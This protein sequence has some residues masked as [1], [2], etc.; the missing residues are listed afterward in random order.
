[1]P[2]TMLLTDDVGATVLDLSNLAQ[3]K[4]V[5]PRLGLPSTSQAKVA[6]RHLPSDLEDGGYR[7]KVKLDGTTLHN[8]FVWNVED[9]GDET[10]CYTTLQSVSPTVLFGKR[11]ARDADGDF[12]KPSVIATYQTG[13]QIMQQLIANSISYEGLLPIT[14]GTV[15]TG[16]VDLSGAPV[17]WPMTIREVQ[18]LLAGTG[19]LDVV[20]VPLDAAAVMVELDLYNGDFGVDRTGSVAFDYATG[21]RNVRAI[22]RTASMEDVCNKLWYYLGPRVLTSSD[23]AGDQHWRANIT[24]DDPGLPNPPGGDVDYPNPLGDLINLSRD[25]FGVMMDIPIYD[26][27]GDAAMLPLYRRRWQVEAML[28]AWPKRML[29]ITPIRGLAPAF[30]FGDLVTVNAGAVLRGGFT[31]AVQRVYA[32]TVAEDENG[33]LSVENIVTSPDQEAL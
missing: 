23:P 10:T 25:R 9:V 28:R 17:D 2:L 19:E 26:G 33:V 15:A 11:P 8:G 1:M 13:P 18:A 22:T 5:T 21:A 27:E 20:E 3:A 24:G 29:S 31:G 16:G 32:Y 14:V 30:H 7:V 12:S 4:Q 6:S